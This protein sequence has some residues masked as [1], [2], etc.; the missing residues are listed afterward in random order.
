MV[1]KEREIALCFIFFIDKHLL[2]QI[3]MLGLSF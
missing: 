2:P 1:A 3:E